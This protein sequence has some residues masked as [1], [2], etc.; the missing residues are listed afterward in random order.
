MENEHQNIEKEKKTEERIKKA[1]RE[2]FTQ[3]GYAA[4][5]TRDIAEASGINLALINYYFRS[6]EKLFDIVMLEQ[7]QKFVSGIIEIIDDAHTSLQEKI[8]LLVAYYIDRLISNPDIPLFVLSEIKA[9]P[10]MLFT[11]VGLGAVHREELYIAKQ[12]KEMVLKRGKPTINPL[13]ILMNIVA[14]TIFPFVGS[15]LIRYRTG[16]STE[17]FNQ[18]MEERKKLIPIWINAIIEAG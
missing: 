6:K 5:R 3:K 16:M 2:V 9:D 13:H 11:K 15:P 1:A 14:M 17:T 7:L 10:S 8:E 4:T 18:L 12:W